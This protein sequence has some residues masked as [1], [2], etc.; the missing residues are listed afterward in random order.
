M[1]FVVGMVLIWSSSA[2]AQ[3]ADAPTLVSY[4]SIFST[5]IAHRPL[6]ASEIAQINSQGTNAFPAIVRSWFAEPQFLESAQMFMENLIRTNG[7]T[8]TVDM[9]IP[10]Y[11]ARDIARRERPYTDFVTA[12]TCVNAAGQNMACDSNAPFS[13]GVL[14]TKAFLVTKAGPYNI[15][16][17]GKMISKFLCTTYPLGDSEEPKIAQSALIDQFATTS[18]KITFGN[19]NNCY[20]CHSQFGHHAQ[21]FVRFDL[22]G[23]YQVGATGIQ[24]PAATDGFSTNGLMTSHYRDPARAADQSSQILGKPAANL[25]EAGRLLAQS[26]RFLPCAVKNLMFHYMRL[27]QDTLDSIK[28][29][30]YIQ[31]ANQAKAVNP[32]PSLSHLL[33]AII[34]N[35][36]V[37]DSFKKSGALP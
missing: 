24:N 19:G 13:A 30:L 27:P 2:L 1:R 18:G 17:A 34:L 7:V 29:D 31:I 15:S 32:D 8:D 10:G 22:N 21:F 5:Q 12:S 23:N 36:N 20:S 4:L 3:V 26:S 16:R 33:S 35:Q 37:L 9:N 14:T 6:K 11:L 25:G 28:P